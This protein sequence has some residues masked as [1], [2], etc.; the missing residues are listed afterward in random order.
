MP[1]DKKCHGTFFSEPLLSGS[2]LQLGTFGVRDTKGY[3][4]ALIVKVS[5]N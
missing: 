2:L 1:P 3:P 5:L 4:F